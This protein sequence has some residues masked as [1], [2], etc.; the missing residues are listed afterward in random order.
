TPFAF[1]LLSY[2]SSSPHPVHPHSLSPLFFF[3]VPPTP[4]IY[5]LSLH[6]ALPIS[7]CHIFRQFRKTRHM[8]AVA[9]LHRSRLDLVEEDQPAVVFRRLDM[10]IFKTGQ[11]LAESRNFMIMRGE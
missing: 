7:V 3:T 8:D 11:C 6:D 2:S 10:D 9:P 1:C 4:E 5:T